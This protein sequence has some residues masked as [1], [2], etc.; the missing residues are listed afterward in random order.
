MSRS[1]HA[2]LKLHWLTTTIQSTTAG[3]CD[4]ELRTTFL[5]NY[6][7]LL[8]CHNNL[9]PPT[10]FS[11]NSLKFKIYVFHT[12]HAVVLMQHFTQLISR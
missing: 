6:R 10:I 11:L 7:L 4:D 9:N 2:I 3:F 12:V 8:G 1:R 5:T